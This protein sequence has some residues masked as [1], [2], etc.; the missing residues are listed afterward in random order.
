V[1]VAGSRDARVAV[2]AAQQRGRV[3]RTQLL[4]AGLTA[5]QVAALVRRDRLFTLH[6]GVYAVGHLGPVPLGAETAALLAAPP[7][8]RLCHRSAAVLWGL[9]SIDPDPDA[10][11]VQIAPEASL[12]RV[13]IRAHRSQFHAVAE[14]RVRHGLPVTSPAHTLLD[15]A[16]ELGEHDL[17][18]AHDEALISGVMRPRDCA[19]VL[20][21]LGTH[22]GAGRLRALIT[23]GDN[24]VSRSDPELRLRSLLADAGLP[25]PRR[26]VRVHGFE[27]DLYWPTASFVVEFDGYRFHGTRARFENDRAR[28]AQLQASGVMVM[29]LTWRQLERESYAVIARIAAAIARRTPAPLR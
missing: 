12:R 28:D 26:N 23:D 11:H 9:V 1:R 16:V 21:R 8:A 2:I 25:H 3:A 13:G 20:A 24:A 17:E 15:L 6:A 5:G 27:V 29:R 14:S 10:V 18:R 4:A 7:D 19:R 22:P